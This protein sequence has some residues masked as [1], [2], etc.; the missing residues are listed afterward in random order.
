M[1]FLDWL[2]NLWVYGDDIAAAI[3]CIWAFWRGGPAERFAAAVIAIGWTATILVK[4][5]EAGPNYIIV[6]I[7]I[8]ALI[9]FVGLAIVARRAWTYFA[10]ACM[11]N[12]VVCHGVRLLGGFGIYSYA[13][14]AGFWSGT[15]LLLCLA[16]GTIGHRRSLKHKSAIIGG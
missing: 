6:G 12:S 14:M 7:D 10:A 9:L 4:S 5:P 8:I 11:L 2:W 3:C 13:S 16:W 15:A 1:K